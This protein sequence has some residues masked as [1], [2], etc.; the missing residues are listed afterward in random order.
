MRHLVA[1]VCVMAAVA[2][3]R[4]TVSYRALELGADPAL[5]GV[6]GGAFAA[7][8]LLVAIPLGSVIDRRGERMFFLVGTLVIGAAA[9]AD[10]S[11]AAVILLPAAQALLGLGHLCAALATQT[12]T[13]RGSVRDRD[14]RFARMAVAASFGQLGGPLLAGWILEQPAPGGMQPTV[15]VFVAALG[16]ALVA[17]I[18]GWTV[19]RPPSDEEVPSPTGPPTRILG[20]IRLDGMRE[21]LVTSI[22]ILTASDIL[23]AYLP[24]LGEEIGISPGFVG[25]LLSIRAGAAIGSR[26]VVGQMIDRVGRRVTLAANVVL[27]GVSMAAMT[28]TSSS[29]LLAVLSATLGF[30]LGL[31]QPITAAWVSGRAPPGRV[32]AAL[33]LR[34]SGNRLGQLVLPATI[35]A[36]AGLAGTA[37][38]FL[39]AAGGLVGSALW[40]RTAPL[41]D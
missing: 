10:A 41:D 19:P 37:L 22:A 40:V 14:R 13:A 34:L 24:V 11:T 27:A 2:A 20:M 15:A 18:L 36:L 32:S 26:L 33:A 28:T 8:P 4:P 7:L 5:I 35:G 3:V 31:G 21:A 38:V 16:L 17:G 30:G 23:I 39:T 25:I 9:V 29:I 6:I 1:Y 12:L